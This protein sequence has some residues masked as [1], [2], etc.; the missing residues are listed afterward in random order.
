[1]KVR[2]KYNATR[3]QTTSVRPLGK[4]RGPREPLVSLWLLRLLPERRALVTR[5]LLEN[6]EDSPEGQGTFM[7]KKGKQRNSSVLKDAHLA[8]PF[9][10]C[11]AIRLHASS[12]AGER[13]V[14]F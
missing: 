11:D 13:A 7:K 3:V 4:G 14:G 8:Q 1:M 10:V 12:R 9:S 2:M 5:M 6:K